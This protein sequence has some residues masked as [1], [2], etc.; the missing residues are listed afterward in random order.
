MKTKLNFFLFG[1]F[2]TGLQLIILFANL[3]DYK[4]MVFY[5]YI[6]YVLLFVLFVYT[7]KEKKI[8]HFILFLCGLGIPYVFTIVFICFEKPLIAYTNRIPFESQKW[9]QDNPPPNMEHNSTRINMIDDLLE[10]HQLIGLGRSDIHSL[11]GE[12]LKS[13]KKQFEHYGQCD[14]IYLLG[15]T[16]LA[17]FEFFNYHWLCINFKDNTVQNIDTKVIRD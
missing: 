6:V 9:K 1:F 16:S 15:S 3:L 8:L 7:F 14:Y 4:N 17:M 5:D 10:N 2:V 12:P 13:S 11:L